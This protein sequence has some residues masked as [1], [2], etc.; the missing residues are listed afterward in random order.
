MG[1]RQPELVREIADAGHE[2]GLHA[3]VHE[4]VGDRT[5]QRFAEETR[6]GKETLE[7]LAGQTVEGFRAP[8]FS[9]TP[10]TPWAPEVLT[11]LG[12][13]YSSSVLPAKNPLFG[14]PGAPQRPFRWE[15]G[16]IEFPGYLYG[17]SGVRLPIFGG[18]YARTL[19]LPF[20][21]RG[22]SA[23]AA[24]SIAHLYCHPY[25]FDPG[26][27]YYVVPDAGPLLSPLLW[28]RRRQWYSRVERLLANPAPPLR[29]R[30]NEAA[31]RFD[32]DHTPVS[33]RSA[34]LAATHG[35]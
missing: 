14:W 13:T 26:E 27:R 17:V 31:E 11:E 29:E 33:M 1:E 30:L 24:D 8:T 12:F 25:D 10:S 28:A 9:I 34:G 5:P 16:L 20:I 4:P 15:S 19:P 18:V 32:L 3:W 35:A 22:F 23:M 2:I 7:Q 21:R 6:R